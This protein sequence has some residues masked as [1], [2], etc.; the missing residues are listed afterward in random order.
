MEDKIENKEAVYGRY[1][2]QSVAIAEI[3]A[4]LEKLRRTVAT[5]NDG[6]TAEENVDYTILA[7]KLTRSVTARGESAKDSWLDLANYSRLIC[8]RRIG[9]DIATDFGL[10]ADSVNGKTDMSDIRLGEHRG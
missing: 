3:V 4:A 8:R 7:M 5:N 2:D 10:I 1:E 9:V 6:L